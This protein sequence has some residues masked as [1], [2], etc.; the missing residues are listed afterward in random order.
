MSVR[1]SRPVS[2][3]HLGPHRPSRTTGRFPALTPLVAFLALAWLPSFQSGGDVELLAQSIP[4]PD[5]HFGHR[6]GADRELV[7][8]EE[9]V[10][11]YRLVGN[12]SN[13]VNVR[14]MGETTD[15]RPFLLLEISSPETVANIDRYKALQQRLYFQ[16]QRPG[17]DP[18]TVHS[19]AE[20][21]ELFRDHKAVVLV[22]ASIHASE[23]GAAQMSL[24]LVHKLATSNDP[25]VGKILDN[26]I[27]LLV[28]SLNPDGMSMVVDWYD[29]YVGTPFEG[30]GMPWLISATWDMTTTATCTCT[31]SRRLASSGRS[32]GRSGSPPYGW[33]S[34]RW[35]PGALASS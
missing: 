11:Y 17:E 5:Q 20:R 4:T 27:F 1:C 24:E 12:A 34:I 31:R 25:V 32:S 23:V 21:A 30:G 3:H 35:D 13:R 33:T 22:T 28:P 6:I 10:E 15:G 7:S 18:N 14:E 2:P 8:W 26:T 19:D 16:D 9:A 29:E